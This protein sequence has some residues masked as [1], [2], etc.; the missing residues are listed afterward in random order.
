M[1]KYLKD[2]SYYENLYDNWMIEACI[3]LEKSILN[4]FKKE[5]EEKLNKE[6]FIEL[7]IMNEKH[8]WYKNRRE[9]VDNMMKKDENIN[10]FI[11]NTP[12]FEW[13]HC[14]L[15]NWLLKYK[16]K[17]F[18]S[19]S[20][21]SP[22]RILFFYECSD[23][24]K[25][26]WIYNDW[27]EII[28]KPNLCNKCW[29]IITHKAKFEWDILIEDFKCKYCWNKYTEKIDYTINKTKK[30]EISEKDRMKYWYNE[31][32]KNDY[33]DWFN[34][35]DQL[36]EIID[37][38]KEREGKKELYEKV[39]NLNK[40]NIVW[41]Q[42]LLNK[43]FQNTNFSDFKIKSNKEVRRWLEVEFDLLFDWNFWENP[44][45]ELIKLFNKVLINTNWEIIKSSINEKLGIIN[46]KLIWYDNEDDL[47]EL[48]EKREKV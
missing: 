39:K 5:D 40:L 12:P 43:E 38:H 23:C 15:C 6:A 25:R 27:E 30:T 28:S 31:K 47:V 18:I 9:R 4:N 7:L 41:L 29:E 2:R 36:S 11:E 44:T 37:K 17:Q 42:K 20:D 32:E 33:I 1:E 16:S 10:T 45:K 35:L 24:N 26:Q 21:N 34:R 14:R 3:R 46:W 13:K 48:I 8:W 19:S 22:N